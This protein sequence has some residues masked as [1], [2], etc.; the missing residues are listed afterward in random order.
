MV[1]PKAGLW[2]EERPPR[3]AAMEQLYKVFPSAPVNVYEFPVSPGIVMAPLLHEIVNESASGL[4]V[5]AQ[6]KFTTL[7]AGPA[8]ALKLVGGLG[9]NAGQLSLGKVSVHAPHV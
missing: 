9:G 2:V 3:T 7:Q 4:F 5:S 8:E 6:K 1:A